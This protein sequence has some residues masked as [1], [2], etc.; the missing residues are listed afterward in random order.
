MRC[1]TKSRCVIDRKKAKNMTSWDAGVDKYGTLGAR[2]NR[3][4]RRSVPD[5][6]SFYHPDVTSKNLRY[7]SSTVLFIS[8]SHSNL[9]YYSRVLVSAS[10]SP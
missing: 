10:D 3:E 5:V 6:L 7:K 8:P 9:T 2:S 4:N 1:T